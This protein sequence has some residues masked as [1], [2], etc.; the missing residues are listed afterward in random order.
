MHASRQSSKPQRFYWLFS[1]LLFLA[2]LWVSAL[3]PTCHKPGQSGAAT[4]GSATGASG[5]AGRMTFVSA[6]CPKCH[7]DL[8]NGGTGAPPL[9]NLKQ[10]WDE[11][12]LAAYLADPVGY[13]QGD[14][15]LAEQAAKYPIS[16]PPVNDEATRRA[17][18]KWLLAQ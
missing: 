5:D 7:G 14:A 10:N 1:S 18:A 9:K 6:G 2:I 15:R 11:D 8:L 3:V 16:M 4:S 17:L 12:K 13:S